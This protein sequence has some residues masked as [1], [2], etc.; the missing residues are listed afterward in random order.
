MV[1]A[2][3]S[4]VTVKFHRD[5]LIRRYTDSADKKFQP[6]RGTRS[7]KKKPAR[8]RLLS[9]LMAQFSVLYLCNLR[10]LRIVSDQPVA[11]SFGHGFGFRMHLQLL[12]DILQMKIDRRGLDPQLC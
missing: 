6:T 11:E 3:R 9:L 7:Q 4:G 2:S 12:I 1:K 10:N 8:F 5:D